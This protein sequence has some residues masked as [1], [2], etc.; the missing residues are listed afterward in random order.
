MRT[1]QPMMDGAACIS[2]F[3]IKKAKPRYFNL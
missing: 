3:M 2:G 1:A